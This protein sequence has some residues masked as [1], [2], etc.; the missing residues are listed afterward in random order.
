MCAHEV[1]S[2]GF[3]LDRIETL[4]AKYKFHILIALFLTLSVAHEVKPWFHSWYSGSVETL[5]AK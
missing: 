5:D 1:L 3:I 4:D 2:H